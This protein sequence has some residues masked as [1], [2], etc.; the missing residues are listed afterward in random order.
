[1]VIWLCWNIAG[2]TF[3]CMVVL[4]SWGQVSNSCEKILKPGSHSGT[5]THFKSTWFG[6]KMI[7]H[8]TITWF[9]SKMTKV[10]GFPIGCV[11]EGRECYNFSSYFSF[12]FYKLKHSL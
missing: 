6:S 4:Q 5:S 1:M 8:L 10:G 3:Q 12:F 2:T 9:G 7:K 11:S